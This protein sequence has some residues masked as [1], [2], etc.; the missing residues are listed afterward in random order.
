MPAAYEKSVFINCPFDADFEPLFHAIV[1]TVAARGFVPRCA[2]E[3]EGQPETRIARIAK[4]ILQS[5]YSIHDLS[6]YQG[7]GDQNLSRFNMPLE[8][9][10]ALGVQYLS[11]IEQRTSGNRQRWC[12]LVP[13][14]L[15]HQQFVSDLAGYDLLDHDGQPATVIKRV[16]SW[17]GKQEFTMNMPTSRA[18]LDAYPGFCQRLDQARAQALGDLIWP[19]IIANG[20]WLQAR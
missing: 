15:V 5:K 10:M 11:D 17:L 7:Q 9:G 19:A 13:P 6:R 4:G 16:A 8:L 2:R 3:T 12:A 18:I 14:G 20:R 1:L